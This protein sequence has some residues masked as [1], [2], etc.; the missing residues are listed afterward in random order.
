MASSTLQTAGGGAVQLKSSLSVAD[1]VQAIFTG[2]RLALT[3]DALSLVTTCG[4]AVKV[5]CVASGR[6]ERTFEGDTEPI[7]AL[8]VSGEAAGSAPLLAAASRSLMLRV[9]DLRT[10][11]LKRA[12]RPH[13]S[14]VLALD[15]HASGALLATGSAD[16]TVKVWDVIQGFCTHN[17]RGSQGVVR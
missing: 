8:A 6:V 17:F 4:D 1:R 12:F 11:A 10:G 14:P 16:A 5:V 3:P 7:T 2:G 9:Y 13:Q 15:F